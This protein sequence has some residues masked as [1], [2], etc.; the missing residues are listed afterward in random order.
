MSTSGVDLKKWLQVP[1]SYNVYNL[2][3][4]CTIQVPDSYNV[5]ER[6]P[7]SGLSGCNALLDRWVEQKSFESLKST[8]TPFSRLFQLDAQPGD[9][10]NDQQRLQ[11]CFHW[12][13]E[14]ALLLCHFRSASELSL[15]KLSLSELSLSKLSLSEPSLSEP[16]FL[17]LPL[18]VRGTVTSQL[19]LSNFPNSKLSIFTFEILTFKTFT[20]ELLLS[21]LSVA[22]LSLSKL[23][24]SKLSLSK[25]SLSKLS[26]SKLS[27]TVGGTVT[28]KL[29][30]S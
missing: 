1:D 8:L 19:Y 7:L 13:F 30:L 22:K 21:E 17:K 29:S 12:N 26:H 23:S 6:V 24:L 16:L 3:T 14:E 18:T 10:R 27:L 5:W 9:L 20:F 2:V 11:A 25:L 28:S 4:V 15:S